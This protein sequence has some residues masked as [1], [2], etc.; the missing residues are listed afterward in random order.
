[1]AGN[2]SAGEPTIFAVPVP[3]ASKKIVASNRMGSDCLVDR[4]VYR[5][6]LVDDSRTRRRADTGN[7]GISGAE[8]NIEIEIV[9]GIHVGG[10]DDSRIIKHIQVTGEDR[11]RVEAP[12]PLR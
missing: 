12:D 5:S 2:E 9:A 8:S 4:G 11:R 7:S 10:L 1:M 6:E 3:T